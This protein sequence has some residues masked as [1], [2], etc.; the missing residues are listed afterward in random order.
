MP[1]RFLRPGIRT[2]DAWNRTSFGAQSL[3]IAIL[4]L[5][6][7]FGRYDARVPILH[8]EC[9]ALRPVIKPQRTAA[10]R[11]E[12]QRMGLIRVY[13]VEGK[14]YLQVTKWHEHA[15]GIRSRFPDE[16]LN[17]QES[18][19]DRS[20]PLPPSPLHHTPLHHVHHSTK[21][22]GAKA[23]A[24]P[25]ALGIEDEIYE[26]YP[27]KEGKDAALRAI[28]KRLN[29]GANGKFML[30]QVKVYAVNIAWKER[31]FIPHPATWFNEGRFNDD[32]A[33]WYD[34]DKPKPQAKAR[35]LGF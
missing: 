9:F 19:A 8:G 20:V 30:D 18:A 23:P 7:D 13:S 27:R 34:P 21:S 28:R 2:S 17:P 24:A 22:N 4:T 6:D 25:P 16:I 12:L 26:A 10:F 35:D 5:V 11:S 14:E 3:Y 31:R 1:Q 29:E 15:R 32:P 33:E